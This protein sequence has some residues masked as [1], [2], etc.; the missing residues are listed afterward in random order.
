MPHRAAWGCSKL[1]PVPLQ[2]TSPADSNRRDVD[3]LVG[4]HA[5]GPAWGKERGK[6]PQQGGKT[7]VLQLRNQA[8]TQNLVQ[9]TDLDEPRSFTPGRGSPVPCTGPSHLSAI[10]FSDLVARLV[11]PKGMTRQTEDSERVFAIYGQNNEI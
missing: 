6:E 11:F 5:T 9:L 8:T 10:Y 4:P 1:N 7:P 3:W 2:D